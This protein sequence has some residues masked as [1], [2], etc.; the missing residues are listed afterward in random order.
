MDG[1]DVVVSKNDGFLSICSP[2]GKIKALW[3]SPC[4]RSHDSAS[5]GRREQS[6]PCLHPHSP[7]CCKSKEERLVECGSTTWALSTVAHAPSPCFQ[8]EV[9]TIAVKQSGYVHIPRPRFLDLSSFYS[10]S[11]SPNPIL[12]LC[13]CRPTYSTK[14]GTF[15][16][17]ILHRANPVRSRPSRYPLFQ[18]VRGLED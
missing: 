3:R 18:S 6:P 12:I 9:S 16:P 8:R 4:H 1:G 14:S 11:R 2:S 7:P 15:P 17:R 13:V 10:R 5:R